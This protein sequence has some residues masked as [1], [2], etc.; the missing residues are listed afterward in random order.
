[1]INMKKC[2]NALVLFAIVI[3]LTSCLYK[4]LPTYP[5]FE[6]NSITSVYVEYRYN[7]NQKMY[8]SP[9][10]VAQKLVVTQT[11]NETNSVINVKL[12]IPAASG[13]FTTDEIAKVSLSNLLMSFD[14][15]TAASIVATGSTSKP[16]YIGDISKPLTYVVTSASGQQRNWTVNV[17]PL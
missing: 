17:A 11:I 5:S 14:I 3:A 7:G 12:T 9:I 1:M 13:G 2:R 8:G 16:G 15:S 4:D 6:G 10:V